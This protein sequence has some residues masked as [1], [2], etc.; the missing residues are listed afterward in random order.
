M[1]RKKPSLD[2]RIGKY[3]IA[4]KKGLT[5]KEAQIAAGYAVPTHS[6]TIEASET[7]KALERTY[8]RD[9]VREKITMEEIADEQIKVIRQDKDLGAKNTAIKNTL[10]KLEPETALR[11]DDER[12][13]VILKA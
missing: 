4:R 1:A 10:E 7:Y 9:K 8:F 12:L 6:A 3:L 13:V 11:E 2:S 5:G